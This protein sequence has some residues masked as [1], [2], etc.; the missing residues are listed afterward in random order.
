MYDVAIRLEN[1][2]GEMAKMG[3]AWGAAK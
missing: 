2:P 3:E 1:K